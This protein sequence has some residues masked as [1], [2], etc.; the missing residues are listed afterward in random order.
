MS[1]WKKT[2]DRM[3]AT[4]PAVEAKSEMLRAIRGYFL[5]NGFT[6]VE[7]P[8]LLEFPALE[9][10]IDAER[11]SSGYLRTSPELAMKKLLAAGYERVFEVG[12]CFRRGERGALHNPEYTMLEWYRAH[13]G[14]MDVL[15][16]T[17]TLICRIAQDVL[18][19]TRITHGKNEIELDGDWET[20]T[21]AEAFTRFAGWN[22]VV[23]FD[24]ERFELDLVSKVEPAL[25]KERPVVLMDYPADVAALA[26]LKPDNKSVAERWELYVGGVELANAFGELTDP[27]EQRVRFD[28][29]SVERVSQGRESYSIDEEFMEALGEMPPAAGVALGV[30]RL[31]MLLTDSQ[32]LDDVLPFR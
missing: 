17:R 32:S 21:V 22:P 13:A 25:S 12:P 16:D 18:G 14:Y 30:D 31:L 4:R 6:E 28:I 27:E 10:N 2:R 9:L 5:D 11:T 20:M 15:A 29:C 7:T 26:R 24:Q 1:N 19:S 23:A 8:V 3:A